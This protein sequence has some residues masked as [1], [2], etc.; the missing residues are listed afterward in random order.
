MLWLGGALA[1]RDTVVTRIGSQVDL[2]PTLLA[3]LHL[4]HEQYRWGRNLLS[5]DAHPFAYFPYLDG[6]GIVDARGR[7]VYDA[8]G[9][10]VM[11]RAGAVG[12]PEVRSGLAYLRLSYQDYLDK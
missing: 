2:A 5:A 3:Q 11:Q 8:L 1:V 10:R 12:E 4:P 7:L 6:F 9:R